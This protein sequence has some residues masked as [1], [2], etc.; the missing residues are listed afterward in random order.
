MVGLPVVAVVGRSGVGKTSFLER[1]VPALRAR[2]LAVGC[3]KHASHGF[4]AD[5]PGKDSYRL[6]ASGADAV[7]LASRHQI[8]TF[9]S[10]VVPPELEVPLVAALATLPRDLDLVLAEGFSWEPVARL[11]LVARGDEP[12]PDYLRAGPVIAVV[13]V[14]P[15]PEQSAPLFAP[16]LVARIAR[17]LAARARAR[18][19]AA[20]R[21]TPLAPRRQD[22]H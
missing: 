19:R 3:V 2:G 10:A 8:A 17:R 6:A 11:V 13:E 15:H 16:A 18:A 14:P 20:S 7:A 21:P 9:R 4:L 1:L 5:R 12:S 22:L